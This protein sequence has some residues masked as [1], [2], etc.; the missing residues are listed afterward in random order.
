MKTAIKLLIVLLLA[1]TTAA[2]QPWTRVAGLP[3]TEFTALEVIDGT[4]LAA[5]KSKLYYSNDGQHW[6]QATIAQAVVEPSCFAK[7]SG[8]LYVGTMAH[9]IYS[10]PMD[11]LSGAWRHDT[12]TLAVSS[13]LEKDGYLYISTLGY[14]LYKMNNVGVF[15]AISNGLPNYSFNVSKVINAPTGIIATAGANGTFYRYDEAANSWTEDL[16][17]HTYSPGLHVDDALR[18]GDAIFVSRNNRLLRSDNSGQT[19]TSDAVGLQNGHYRAMYAGQDTFYTMTNIF[20][21]DDNITFL[22]KRQLNAPSQTNWNVDSEVLPFYTYALRE[23]AGTLFAAGNTGLFIKNA[24]LG[25]EIPA[26]KHKTAIYPN[27]SSDSRFTIQSDR[28]IDEIVVYDVTGKLI[29]S[30]PVAA[31]LFELEVSATGAYLVKVIAQ[32]SVEH[33]KIISQ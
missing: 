9:G 6:E 24:Q 29:R 13:F 26:V 23:F 5:A 17:S 32:D 11:N 3:Q 7:I 8:R 19:W 20:T 12:G 33:F 4:L 15:K 14:G 31:D 2:A 30:T 27:P 16:Y 21:G 28:T 22:R 10:A 25:I 18:I 1:F